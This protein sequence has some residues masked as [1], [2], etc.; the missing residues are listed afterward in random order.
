MIEGIVR[1]LILNFD[2]EK[3]LRRLML[4]YPFF[5]E[6]RVN[7][8]VSRFFG[9]FLGLM[10]NKKFKNIENERLHRCYSIE[11]NVVLNERFIMCARN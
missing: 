11:I 5:Y 4:V 6:I 2:S 1:F 3:I 9:L 7:R 8:A 10:S